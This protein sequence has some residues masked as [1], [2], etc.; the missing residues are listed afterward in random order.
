MRSLNFSIRL[1]ADDS[2]YD[3]QLFIHSHNL[4]MQGI[5]QPPCHFDIIYLLP[6]RSNSVIFSPNTV[7]QYPNAG[8]EYNASE[9]KKVVCE[10]CKEYLQYFLVK[11]LGYRI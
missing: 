3:G 10:L 8:F 1:T 2:C 9:K 7:A 4:L 5:V 11:I 6:C